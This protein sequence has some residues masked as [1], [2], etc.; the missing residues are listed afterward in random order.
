MNARQSIKEIKPKSSSKYN[1]SLIKQVNGTED[2]RDKQRKKIRIGLVKLSSISNNRTGQS[3]QT[4]TLLMFHKIAQMYRDI[5]NKKV[6]KQ[7]N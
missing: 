5:G 4:L 1:C 3:D 2:G 7:H 6:R